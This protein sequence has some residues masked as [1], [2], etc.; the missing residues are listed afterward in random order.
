MILHLLNQ[1]CDVSRLSAATKTNS[2][3]FVTKTYASVS[4]GTPCR[5]QRLN[6]TSG[7]SLK[8]YSGIESVNKFLGMLLSDANVVKGDRIVWQDNT[9]E[10]ISILPIF[11]GTVDIHHLE[12]VCELEA[13]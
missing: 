9:L 13:T 4:I 5:F 8:S 1:T 7:K 3:G 11:A 2:Q 10:V 12:T 6:D